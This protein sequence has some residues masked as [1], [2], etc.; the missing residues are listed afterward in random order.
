MGVSTRGALLWYRA[1]QSLALIDGKDF[2][3]PDHAKQLAV[4][5]LSHRVAPA[6]LLSGSQKFEIEAIME[7]LVDDVD[8]PS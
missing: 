8:V 6:Q 4:P 7:R 2:A 5:V 1:V 3:T